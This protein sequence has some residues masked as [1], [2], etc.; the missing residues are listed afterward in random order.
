MVTSSFAL[1][2]AA[3]LPQ[4]VNTRL[5][6]RIMKNTVFFILLLPNVF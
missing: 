3:D 6:P 1:G 5:I 4:A 2:D